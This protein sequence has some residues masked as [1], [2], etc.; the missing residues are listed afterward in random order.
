MLICPLGLEQ[1]DQK[2]SGKLAY[3]HLGWLEG[4]YGTNEGTQNKIQTTSKW[5]QI[6]SEINPKKN[7]RNKT[8]ENHRKGRHLA[9]K[10]NLINMGNKAKL[11]C[12]KTLPKM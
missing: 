7:K 8:R 3:P 9:K 11:T 5:N 12:F 6:E 2:V 10:T 1:F 4:S